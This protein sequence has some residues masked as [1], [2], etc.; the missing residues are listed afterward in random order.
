MA[1]ILSTLC[2]APLRG[3]FV[4]ADDGRLEERMERIGPDFRG[5]ARTLPVLAADRRGS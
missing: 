3:G 4:D 1:L 2:A 5:R